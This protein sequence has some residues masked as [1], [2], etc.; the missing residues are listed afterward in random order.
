MER[1]TKELCR[2]LFQQIPNGLC[3]IFAIGSLIGFVLFLLKRRQ[4]NPLRFCFGTAV[5]FIL[6]WRLVVGV[7]AT[8]YIS[9]LVIPAVLL[10][11][12][13]G[14][15]GRVLWRFFCKKYPRLPRWF[16]TFFARAVLLGCSGGALWMAYHALSSGQEARQELYRSLKEY[17][18]SISRLKVLTAE[19]DV[20]RSRYYTGIDTFPLLNETR[21]GIL[22][23]VLAA[24]KDAP[25]IAVTRSRRNETPVQFGK[26]ELPAGA[27]LKA[28]RKIDAENRKGK[29]FILYLYTPRLDQKGKSL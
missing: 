12:F 16:G 22:R 21:Q 26:E 6:S 23:S 11:A 24:G 20:S 10:T 15:R 1:M 9:I 8:R 13:V 4:H 14:I 17:R 7:L 3:L 28:V 29:G 19:D 2:T 27:V 5:A 18:Q 25:V